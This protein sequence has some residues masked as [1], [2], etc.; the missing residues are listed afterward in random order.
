MARRD[1]G[2]T[3]LPPGAVGPGGRAVRTRQLRGIGEPNTA[4]GPRAGSDRGGCRGVCRRVPAAKAYAQARRL[5]EETIA[6]Q[7]QTLGPRVIPSHVLLQEGREGTASEKALRAVLTLAP[8]HAEARRNL[9]LLVQ[10]QREN[11]VCHGTGGGRLGRRAFR[12]NS[13]ADGGTVLR[14][15]KVELRYGLRRQPFRQPFRHVAECSL[16]KPSACEPSTTAFYV[17]W[18][19]DAFHH[20]APRTG[21][22]CV[23][24][25]GARCALFYKRLPL[26]GL[27]LVDRRARADG[28]HGGVPVEIV[29]SILGPEDSLP[30][31]AQPQP[32]PARSRRR[33]PSIV[34]HRDC[35]NYLG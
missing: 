30:P 3:E 15:R 7:S 1:G 27:R 22:S 17:P 12:Q 18:R 6:Y 19:P 5:L 9:A 2:A 34:G 33:P 31:Y 11:V 10:R 25:P 28:F 21:K 23:R 8:H 24:A 13:V 29:K 14:P 20:F 26:R 32:T 35:Y 4:P 16:A